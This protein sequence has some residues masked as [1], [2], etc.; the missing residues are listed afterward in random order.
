MKFLY[1][2]IFILILS[3]CSFVDSDEQLIN[4]TIIFNGSF[5]D[6]LNYWHTYGDSI[7]INEDEVYD[8]NY[9]LHINTSLRDI[10][11]VYQYLDRS[12]VQIESSF[13]VFPSSSN[14]EQAIQ[15]LANWKPSSSFDTIWI[16]Q[17]QISSESIRCKSLDS[18][19]VLPSSLKQ[20]K[21]NTISIN[22]NST[23]EIDVFVNDTLKCSF[24]NADLIPIETLMLGDLTARA[25]RGA[26]CYDDILVQTID[27]Y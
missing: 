20:N 13:K 18:L 4:H 7:C 26:V 16:V 2:V 22:S 8:G 17:I 25:Q 24:L 9:S 27:E 23:G 3:S 11:Y 19:I 15:F 10:A 21:W 1:L 6:S 14:Y 5:E 12:S